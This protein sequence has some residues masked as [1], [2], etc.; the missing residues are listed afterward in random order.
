MK[1]TSKI[2]FR[3]TSIEKIKFDDLEFSYI[4]NAITKHKKIIYIFF[5]KNES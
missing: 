4:K 3:D 2:E 1:E 5:I